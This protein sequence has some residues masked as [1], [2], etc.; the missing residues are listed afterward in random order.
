MPAPSGR[1]HDLAILLARLVVGAVFVAH[2]WQKF[3]QWGINGTAES[4]G[5]MGIPLPGVAAWAVALIETLGGLALM[6]GAALPVAGVLLALTMLG[7]LFV[8]H[9][10]SG[11]FAS[12]GGFEYVL[13][14][15]VVALVLSSRGGAWSVDRVLLRRSA[16]TTT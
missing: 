5:Q 13:V 15:A 9:L 3:F 8:A 1:M 2:G 6:L 7:A 4:F 11:F 14:L 16:A 10:S 12:D